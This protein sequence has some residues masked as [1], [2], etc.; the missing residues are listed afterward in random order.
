MDP[1][2]AAVELITAIT[3]LVTK[4]VDGQTPEQRKQIWDWYIQD[5]E[6]IRKLLKIDQ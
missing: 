1:I 3:N 4:I 2:T 5:R 6:N